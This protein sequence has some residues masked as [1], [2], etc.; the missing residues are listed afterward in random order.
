M[1]YHQINLAWIIIIQQMLFVDGAFETFYAE[2]K[3]IIENIILCDNI[4]IKESLVYRYF[5]TGESVFHIAGK[6]WI[7]EKFTEKRDILIIEG[8]ND[9]RKELKYILNCYN[10]LEKI[11]SSDFCISYMKDFSGITLFDYL[12]Q[13]L[14]SLEKG[15][16]QL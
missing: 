11:M 5:Y 13:F 14:N 9:I 12:Q 1:I 3:D 4:S 10:K 16:V 15:L 8:M 6:I 2:Y 7:F